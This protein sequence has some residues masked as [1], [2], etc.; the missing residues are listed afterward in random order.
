MWFNAYEV[1]MSS[2]DTYEGKPNEDVTSRDEQRQTL[3]FFVYRKPCL[4]IFTEVDES[5]YTT[6]YSRDGV[7]PSLD[8]KSYLA[9]ANPTC[10]FSSKDLAALGRQL[11][12]GDVDTAFDTMKDLLLEKVRDHSYSVG[13]ALD[14]FVTEVG[15]TSE[16]S[17][18]SVFGSLM[19][20]VVDACSSAW[21]AFAG[22][23]WE[24]PDRD[25]CCNAQDGTILNPFATEAGADWYCESKN[26]ATCSGYVTSK[27]CGQLVDAPGVFDVLSTDSSKFCATSG[28]IRGKKGSGASIT[29]INRC[30]AGDSECKATG[31]T[32]C[33]SGSASRSCFSMYSGWDCDPHPNWKVWKDTCRE[34][35]EEICVKYYYCD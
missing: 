24:L 33:E 4:I 35:Y 18:D 31:Q 10:D 29:G 12:A 27:Y 20:G 7:T 17:T 23:A 6:W 5:Q 15:F 28:L 1:G 34:T 9:N 19:G 8:G 30:T 25:P 26:L 22:E 32:V 2:Y 21:E 14:A 16:E 13:D 11:G 3:E